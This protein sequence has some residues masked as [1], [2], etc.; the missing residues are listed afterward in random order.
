VR[1]ILS[2]PFRQVVIVDDGSG[3]E[4]SDT[5]ARLERMERVTV[6]RHAVNMGKGAA[7]KTGINHVC[8]TFRDVLGIVTVD[9]DGQ[10]SVPDVA[11][12]AGALVSNPS[13]AVL[14][15]RR[16]TSDVPLRSYVGNRITRTLLRLLVGMDLADTQ[17][18][19]RGVPIGLAPSLLELRS[20]HYEFELE[21]LVL[22]KHRRTEI[23]QVPISTIYEEGNR[24]SHF[25]PLI[26]SG[27]I[28]FVL[29]R[30]T[31]AS[32]VTAAFDN[33]I[34]FMMLFSGSS[35]LGSQA[36]S[37]FFGLFLNYVLVKNFVFYSDQTHL[38]VFPKYLAAVLGFGFISYG[39]IIFLV[40]EAGWAIFPAKVLVETLSYIANFAV[41]RELIFRG[42]SDD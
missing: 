31:L 27:K 14:G 41:Q 39:M 6:L 15:V 28:Y 23:I 42:R 25:H 9:A 10:H 13:C 5:L 8:V 26:D 29:L 2:F 21:T 32:L 19:L 4:F 11:S 18:G 1:E 12:V 37:R 24:S 7:L 38:R 34:F 22:L 35:I 16:F 20:Q 33:V 3:A 40:T 17:T 30:F 36:T